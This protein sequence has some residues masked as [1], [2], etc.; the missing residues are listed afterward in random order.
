MMR[1]VMRVRW[2]DNCTYG[3]T[4]SYPIEYDSAEQALIDFDSYIQKDA[5]DFTF[6][7]VDFSSSLFIKSKKGES[8]LEYPEFLTLDEWFQQECKQ[9]TQNN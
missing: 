7:G 3:F 5:G 2:T 6:L 9:N 8:T 1:L 4:E